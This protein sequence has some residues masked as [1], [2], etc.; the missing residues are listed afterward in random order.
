[1]EKW[2]EVL[3]GIAPV[4]AG[5]LGG[6]FAAAAAKVI[7]DKV[8]GRPDASEDDV[9]IAI[10]SGSL[11]GD[12][13]I[14]LKA[15]EQQFQL[16]VHKIT[17]ETE[18]AYLIDV[19]DARARQ[20]ETKD[21]MPQQIFYIVFAA[22]V[23]QYLLFYFGPPINDQFIQTLI[24]KAFGIT[25]GALIGAIAYFIGSSRGSKASGDAVRKIAENS[26]K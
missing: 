21:T 1:M 24:I 16:D 22:Y 7:A 19:Q 14:A 26:S 6:P 9:K 17:A 3:G 8:L 13:L 5:A 4:L 12:Q 11:S 15:A 20:V 2:Q 23:M 18:R 10:A 25:E